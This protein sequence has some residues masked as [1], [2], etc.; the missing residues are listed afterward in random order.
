MIHSLAGGQL[1]EK[2]I[3]DF[4]KVEFD[5]LPEQYFWFICDISGIKEGD[6]IIAPFGKLDEPRIAKVVQLLKNVDAQNVPFRTRNMKSI[7][8]KA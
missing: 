8:K 4:V 2:R 6:K 7:Y 1:R 3:C 5:R